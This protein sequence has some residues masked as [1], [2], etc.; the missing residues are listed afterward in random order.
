MRNIS[1]RHTGINPPN[2]A[3]RETYKGGEHYDNHIDPNEVGPLVVM[4]KDHDL[5]TVD[6]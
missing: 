3:V 5:Y 6:I 1:F 2:S 4:H